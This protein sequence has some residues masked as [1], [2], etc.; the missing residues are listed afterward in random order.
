MKVSYSLLLWVTPKVISVV[1]IILSEEIEVVS[2]ATILL[3]L[4]LEMR[5]Y[6]CHSSSY[7]SCSAAFC[8]LTV[9]VLQQANL[10][11]L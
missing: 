2:A 7:I 6:T 8:A 9:L 1:S 4:C 3:L 5:T 11:S 10:S